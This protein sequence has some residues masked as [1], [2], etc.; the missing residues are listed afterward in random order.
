MKNENL[1]EKSYKVIKSKITSCEYI[2][3]E[4]INESALREEIGVSRTPIREALSRLEQENL[5]K[6]IPKRGVLVT[7]ISIIEINELF[8]VRE[9]I[10]PYIIRTYAK[11]IDKIELSRLYNILIVKVSNSDIEAYSIDED[12][13]RLLVNSS[14]NRYFVSIMENIYSQNHRIRVLTGKQIEK[15]LDQTNKEHIEILKFLIQEDWDSA[16]SSMVTHLKNSKMV[17]V[18]RWYQKNL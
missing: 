1:K 5:V 13:H 6:I 14:N 3:N 18:D 2:P 8:Q 7:D 4:F 16:A 15:R 12:I 11:N 10:E 9:L 17:A